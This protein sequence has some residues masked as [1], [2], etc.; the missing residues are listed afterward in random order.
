MITCMCVNCGVEL[1]INEAVDHIGATR[2]EM[3]WTTKEVVQR[4]EKNFIKYIKQAKQR[5]PKET[6]PI[7]IYICENG[8]YHK[9]NG[10]SLRE[11][12]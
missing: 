11:N 10:C 6:H 4:L 5:T 9:G 3:C 1:Q 12:C 7:N 2:C 8:H